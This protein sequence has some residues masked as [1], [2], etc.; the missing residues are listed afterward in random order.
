[1]A[2]FDDK[3]YIDMPETSVAIKGARKMDKKALCALAR[4]F[5]TIASEIQKRE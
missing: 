1:M 4:M 2:V 5:S 3:P